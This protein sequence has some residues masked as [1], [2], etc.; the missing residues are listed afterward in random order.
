MKNL[1]IIGAGGHGKVC[2]E[3]SLR[4][5]K[6][7]NISFLDDLNSGKMVNGYQIFKLDEHIF[8]NDNTDYFVAIGNNVTRKIIT[9]K[10]HSK[11]LSV[12][13]LIDPS[14]IV[15]KFS[16]VGVGT[17]VLP[18]AVINSNST[19]EM[20]CIVNSNSVVEHDCIV[21][22]YSHMS[23][24]S[25][26]CGNVSVGKLSWLGSGT[27]VLNDISIAPKTIIGAN[28]TVTKDILNS[29]TYIGSPAK[30]LVNKPQE[31]FLDES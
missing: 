10:L 17:V 2:L 13:T 28:S 29:G 1:V 27:V 15:S 9:T 20:G 11:S 12:A 16:D 25:V 21:G 8:D 22:D 5:G 6:W 3:V 31:S 24:G 4:M 7:S 23:P 14:A 26:I 18:G 19:I 30:L